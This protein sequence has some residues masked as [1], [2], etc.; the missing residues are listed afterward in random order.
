MTDEKTSE[1]VDIQE[2]RKKRGRPKGTPNK[3]NSEDNDKDVLPVFALY[4]TLIGAIKRYPYCELPAFPTKLVLI[5]DDVHHRKW[6]AVDDDKTLHEQQIDEIEA[7]VAQYL[8]SEEFFYD[9][10]EWH[11]LPQR[12]KDFCSFLSMIETTQTPKLFKF[13]DEPALSYA[14]I[15]FDKPEPDPDAHTPHFDEI[16]SRVSEPEALGAWIGSL[17]DMETKNDQY[18][19]L[20]GSGGDSK[21]A[22]SRLL[23]ML[24]GATFFSEGL[25]DKGANRFW[26]RTI[27]GR[28]VVVFPDTDAVDFPKSGTFKGMTGQDLTRVEE[29]GG[30][31]SNKAM[32]AKF[33]F[34]SQHQPKLNLDNADLRRIIYLE[35]ESVKGPPDL[36]FQRKL[37]AEAE[38]IVAKCLAAWEDVKR[39]QRGTIVCNSVER[40]TDSDSVQNED[41]E[42]LFDDLFEFRENAHVPVK[43]VSNFLERRFPNRKDAQECRRWMLSKGLKKTTVRHEGAVIKAWKGIKAKPAY[44]RGRT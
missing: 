43:M 16:L 33:L 12:V 26:T 15:P 30:A 25:D 9:K 10:F 32:K 1:T 29:K 8:Y 13:K 2:A 21:G 36:D 14:T 44:E 18:V 41:F 35:I 5:K 17:F 38:G 23:Q 20:K 7:Q 28:R 27:P 22:L 4:R 11:W 39:F 31:T 3:K 34:L 40:L 6:F 19:W 24:F 42:V 37:N